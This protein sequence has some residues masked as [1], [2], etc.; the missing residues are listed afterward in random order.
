MAIE[1]SR[2]TGI[3][4]RADEVEFTRRQRT[5]WGD[6]F[7]QFRRHRFGMIGL[8]IFGVLIVATLLGPFIY[9]VPVN[10]IDF[11]QKLQPPS[12][13][14]PLGTDD[15]GEDILSRVL[16]GGRVS[17]AVG[18]TAM[19]ISIT[20]G[21]LI[22]AVSGFFTGFVDNVLMRFTDL[23]LALPGL[24]L[25]LLVIYLFRDRV[26]HALGSQMGIFLLI[27]AI[28]GGLAW[29]RVARLVRAEFLSIKEKEYIEAA[30]SIGV[31]T[32][33]IIAVHILPNALSPVIVAGTLGVGGAILTESTLSFLGLGFPPDFPTWGR[34]LFDAQN[35]L[36]SAPWWALAPG[37]CIFLAVLSINFVGDGLRD[38][39]DPRRTT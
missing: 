30:R 28:I 12:F 36:D 8:V 39:L 6:A 29:M 34:L 27:V 21:T 32:W 37:I 2:S 17:I 18:L 14:H 11:A 9:K 5:L 1:T 13:T 15:L 22:G 7:R 16:N 33:R 38:A 25:L 24:P 20:L 10:T 31:P 23:M 26:Q 4:S 3:A 35:R 19:I